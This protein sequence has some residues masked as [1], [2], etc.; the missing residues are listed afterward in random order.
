MEI[1]SISDESSKNGR[2]DLD[3]NNLL[4]HLDISILESEKRANG[5]LNF[6]DYYIVYLIEVKVN[7]E[8]ILDRFSKVST[9]WRRYTEFEQLHEYLGAK[10]PYIVIPPLPEKSVLFTWQKISSDTFD[11]NFID[12]RRAGLENFLLRIASHNVLCW[13]KQFAEFLQNE[14]GWRAS[15]NLNGY[16]KLMESTLKS[17]SLTAKPTKTTRTESQQVRTYSNNLYSNLYS[18]LKARAKVVDKQYTIQ[19]LHA[20]YGRLFSE[21]SVIEREMGDS[22]QKIGHYMDSL[23]SSIDIA[24][25]E[26]EIIADQLKEYLFFANSLQ[27]IC[28]HED[29]LQHNI[30][31]LVENVNNKKVEREK[32][33]CGSTSIISRFFGAAPSEETKEVRKNALDQQIEEELQLISKSEKELKE[34]TTRA[35]EDTAR[36]QQQKDADLKETLANFSILQLKTAKRNLQTWI[37]IRECLL[38]M[39]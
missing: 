3:I 23:A 8:E 16:F 7:N 37:H 39:N 2:K 12:R 11:P 15:N 4:A 30:D 33:Q 20:N 17:I 34:F 1:Q 31:K 27:D 26:E 28:R 18:L 6:R 29:Y 5:T 36:F 35:V 21:W 38:K 32:A 10:Y 13:D 14:E 19:K 9:V 25:E 24:L 22:L